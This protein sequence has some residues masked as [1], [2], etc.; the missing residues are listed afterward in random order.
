MAVDTTMTV[1]GINEAI[2]SLNKLEP[3]LR[4]VVRQEAKTIAEP[5]LSAV[6]S[7]YSYIPPSGNANS[8]F[9]RKWAG[10]AVKGRKVFPFT[11][12]KARKGVDLTFQTDRRTLGTI[13]IVQKDAGTAIF[14]SAGRKTRNIMSVNLKPVRAG[15]TRVIGPV[16]YSKIALIEKA[17]EKFAVDVVNRVN[18]ELK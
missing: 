6:R 13:I 8:G 7:A 10:P 5:A 11:L 14:E 2:R 16:V 9:S 12:A 4:K 17:M 3:G 1:A 18:R 15:R